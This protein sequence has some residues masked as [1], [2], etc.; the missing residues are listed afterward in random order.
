[1]LTVRAL[2]IMLDKFVHWRS[3]NGNLK[4]HGSLNCVI[5]R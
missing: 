5:I 3:V 2:N 1:M 4:K